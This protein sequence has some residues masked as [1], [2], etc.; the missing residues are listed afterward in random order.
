MSRSGLEPSLE[1]VG[2]LLRG[3]APVSDVD[4]AVGKAMLRRVGLG[5][6]VLAACIATSVAVTELG[7]R[8]GVLVA[9]V[10]VL[11]LTVA[12]LLRRHQWLHHSLAAERRQLR[13]AVDN[14]PQGLVLYDASARIVVCNQPYID[15]FGLSADIAKQGCTMQRL[16]AHR[17]ET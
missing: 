6:A 14:I 13:T 8:E 7:L 17:Q 15:M 4:A 1:S 16:I 3:G 11:A 9:F 2:R 12:L 5:G 10:A